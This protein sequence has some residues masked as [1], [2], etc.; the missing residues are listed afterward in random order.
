MLDVVSASPQLCYV[1]QTIRV[2][3]HLTSNTSACPLD[4]QELENRLS[5]V[6]RIDRRFYVN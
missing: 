1:N 3:D 2:T 6:D 5:L 4:S